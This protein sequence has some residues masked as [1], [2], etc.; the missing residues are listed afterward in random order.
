MLC[1]T[2]IFLSSFSLPISAINAYM[3]NSKNIFFMASST[4]TRAPCA[5]CDNKGVGIFKCEG[6]SQIFCRKHVN[7]HRENLSHQLDEIVL[8][9]D[10]L[11]Q[12][13]AEQNDQ[14]TNRHSLLRQ[15]EEWEKDSIIKIQQAA[16]ETRKQVEKLTSSQKGK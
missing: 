13:L 2:N 6:C 8:E 12:T 7:E 3:K 16:E 11:Q 1:V 10:T 5:T 4:I 15:I 14:D 9:H